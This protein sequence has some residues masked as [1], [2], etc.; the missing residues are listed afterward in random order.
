MFSDWGECVLTAVHFVERAHVWVLSLPCI[1]QLRGRFF[2]TFAMEQTE[3]VFPLSVS[4]ENCV[5]AENR[6]PE[7]A[8]CTEA[9]RI[10]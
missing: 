2:F 5:G 1:M 4:R 10:L 7:V 9:N 3:S 6:K 8:D